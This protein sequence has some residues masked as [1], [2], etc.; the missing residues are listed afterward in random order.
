MNPT[1]KPYVFAYIWNDGKTDTY[2]LDSASQK[3]NVYEVRWTIGPRG[4]VFEGPQETHLDTIDALTNNRQEHLAVAVAFTDSPDRATQV[5]Y[6]RRFAFRLFEE[7][8]LEAMLPPEEL[9]NPNWP[10]APWVEEDIDF[11]L[12]DAK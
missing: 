11:V 4:I 5:I 7:K 2:L 10:T 6:E 9:H 12:T 8:G 1:N 3:G